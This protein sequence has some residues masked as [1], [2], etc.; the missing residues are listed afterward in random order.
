MSTLKVNAIQSN[1]TQSINVNSNLGNISNIEVSGVSTFSG[2]VVISSGSTSAPSISPS[3]DSNT[4][5]FFPAAD[6]IAF[7]EGGVE[8]LRINSSANIG[9]GTANPSTKVHILGT[10]NGSTGS[11]GLSDSSV[12]S[13]LLLKPTTGSGTALALG[14]RT[15][16]GHY[17]QGLYDAS[18]VDSVRDVQINPYGGSVGIGTFADAFG[19]PP[20]SSTFAVATSGVERLRIDSSGRR[21]LP[22]QP[23]AYVSYSGTA[24]T[25]SNIIPFT[26]VT[27]Q[28]GHWNNS[29]YRF[30]CPVAGVYHASLNMTGNTTQS[31]QVQ[32]SIRQNLSSIATSYYPGGPVSISILCAANDYIDFFYNHDNAGYP[33]ATPAQASVYLL[34]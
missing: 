14:S 32:S 17:I 12:A 33:G 26:A 18:S 5:I 34:G 25:R 2:G 1:T 22:Y 4:G 21:T 15:T 20:G 23:M 29:T 7:A 11:T 19:G 28:G 31:V 24:I 30:T 13:A 9:I 10:G 27:N 3:G 8:A 16:G 6:T